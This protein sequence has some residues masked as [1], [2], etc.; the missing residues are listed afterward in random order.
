MSDPEVKAYAKASRWH[1]D[2]YRTIQNNIEQRFKTKPDLHTLWN[3]TH[4]DAGEVADFNRHRLAQ[5]ID[6]DLEIATRTGQLVR[7]RIESETDTFKLVGAWK[8][9]RDQVNATVKLAEDHR[10]NNEL[11][12]AIR[13]ELRQKPPH[14]LRALVAT[15]TDVTPANV[16]PSPSWDHHRDGRRHLDI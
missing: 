10:N 6:T 7:D 9:A 4:E 8:T 14:E 15:L 16:D 3:W 12:D 2:S 11:L 1:G 5:I 13:A